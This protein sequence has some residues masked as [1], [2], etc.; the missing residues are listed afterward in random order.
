MYRKMVFV[1]ST[2]LLVALAGNA[3]GQTVPAGGWTEDA[4]VGANTTPGVCRRRGVRRPSPCG[5]GPGPSRCV[6]L[7]PGDRC[8][9]IRA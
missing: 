8:R 9:S 2:A 4:T 6:V 3:F 5:S 7:V 1:L